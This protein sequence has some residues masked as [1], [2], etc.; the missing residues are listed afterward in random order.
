MTGSN[1]GRGDPSGRNGSGRGRGQLLLMFGIGLG[2]LL[3]AW[4]LYSLARDGG[5]MGTTNRG[6]FVEP[7]ISVEELGLTWRG[8]FAA[9]GTPGAREPF[10]TGGTWWLWV[11]PDGACGADCEEALYQLRQLHVLLN[12]DADRV[13]RALLHDPSTAVDGAALASRFPR[14]ESV[15]GNLGRL[16]PGVYVVDPIGNLVFRYP[17]ADPGDAMLDDL[18]RLLRVSQI[19]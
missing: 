16:E 2:S 4:L 5:V 1:D 19:G 14:L 7:P 15:S 17:L 8:S 18:K 6:A 13:R 11:V 10:A 9:A 12:R 3:G